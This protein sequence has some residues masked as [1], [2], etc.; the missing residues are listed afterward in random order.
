MPSL[1]HGAQPVAG[2]WRV[3]AESAAVP[4]LDRGL[5]VGDGLFEAVR[6]A[7]GRLPL[8]ERHLARLEEGCRLLGLPRPPWDLAA[9]ARDVVRASG[10]REGVLRITLTRGVGPRGYDPPPEVE[11]FC[12]LTV[13][14]QP[15]GR[16]PPVPQRAVVASVPQVP[17]PVLGRV[18]HLSALP[19]VLARQEARARGAD[20]ALLLTPE[21]YLAEGAATNLF[22][23]SAGRLFTPA[24]V[25]G[26][27]PGIARAWVLSWVARR[28]IS[29]TEGTWGLEALAGAEEAFLTN[30]VSGPIPLAEVEGIARWN[31]P[32][33]LTALLVEAWRR[34]LAGPRAPHGG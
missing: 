30:A 10:V 25:T 14:P 16:T 23:V 2:G 15:L 21:G 33:P 7:G 28:G 26:C 19:R 17:H 3:P 22:W 34:L 6:I 1:D 29:T 27:L 11:P 4:V 31:A 8:L 32:G 5:L 20:E 13:H 12:A 18:K 24:P 9:A